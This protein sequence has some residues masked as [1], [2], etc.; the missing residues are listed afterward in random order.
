MSVGG[1]EIGD[2]TG[3]EDPEWIRVTLRKSLPSKT[4]TAIGLY[5]G[6]WRRFLWE[7]ELGD[8]C[9]LPT[10][11]R[12][13]AIGEF[14]GPYHYAAVA[15]P[16][17]RHRRN[18]GWLSLSVPREAF[19]QDLVRTLN[20]QHTVQE[21]KAPDAAAR[22]RV[23]AHTGTDPGGAE[24]AEPSLQTHLGA[25]TNDRSGTPPSRSGARGRGAGG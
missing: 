17:A 20:A 19:G 12:N 1:T 22:L 3:L 13:V 25:H 14:A 15:E 4:P 9:V 6:Y 21:F 11:R 7:A 10:R 23:L 24:R 2:L 5:V 18:V 8:L 16:R